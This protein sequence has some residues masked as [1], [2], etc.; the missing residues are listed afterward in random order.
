MLKWI[1]LFI[2]LSMVTAC[3]SISDFDIIEDI[4]APDYVSSSRARKLEIPPDLS[5]I[6][7]QSE[8]EV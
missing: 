6:E 7:T 1:R 3:S 4:T 2:A 5:Q 8:Y